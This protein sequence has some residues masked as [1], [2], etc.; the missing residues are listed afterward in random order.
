MYEAHGTGVMG[1]IGAKTN[2]TIG[3]AGI[4]GGDGQSAGVTIIPVRICSNDHPTPGVYDHLLAP[5]IRYAV[6]VGARIINISYAVFKDSP[7]SIYAAIDSAIDYAVQNN[8]VLIAASGNQGPTVL[9]PASHPDVIAVGAVAKDTLKYASSCYGDGLNVVA[10][11]VEIWST[12]KN[13]EYGIFDK[14][15]FSTPI[16]SGIAALMLSVNPNLE[17]IQIKNIIETTARKVRSGFWEDEPYYEYDIYPKYPNG[18]WC[19]ALG[20]GLV[21]AY[22]A[23]LKAKGSIDSIHEWG[24]LSENITIYPNPTTGELKIETDMRYEIMRCEICD[25]YGRTVSYNQVSSL[26]LN[27]IQDQNLKSIDISHLHSGIYFVKISTD[28]GEVVKKIV[29]Q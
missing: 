16:V 5:A 7:Q 10:P 19:P 14:T 11:G 1:V 8:V 3:V 26:I 28:A 15:S 12:T 9:Y 17:N 13:H 2:N 21:D 27:S 4:S 24:N 20:Y 22:A 29:K 18:L 25:M 6:D 23:V